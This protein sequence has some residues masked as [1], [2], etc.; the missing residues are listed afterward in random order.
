MRTYAYLGPK[1]EA[2]GWMDAVAKGHSFESNGPLLEFRIN[3]HISGEAVYLPA[4]GGEIEVQA[5]VWSTL[6][7]TRA[8]IYRNSAVWKGGAAQRG[9]FD[10]HACGRKRT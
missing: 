7:L 5:Q 3:D 6:P 10:R 9:S 2:R 4:G 1:L 8:V